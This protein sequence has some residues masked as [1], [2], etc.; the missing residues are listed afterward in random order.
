MHFVLAP[1]RNRADHYAAAM[2][3]AHD[4]W[5]AVSTPRAAEGAIGHVHILPG[6]AADLH[7]TGVRLGTKSPKHALI[8]LTS[9]A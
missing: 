2:G 4:A 6:T 7:R 8:D 1:T 9:V 5:R 3:W